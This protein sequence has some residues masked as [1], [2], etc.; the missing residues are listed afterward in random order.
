MQSTFNQYI[1]KYL[2]GQITRSSNSETSTG[3]SE[4]ASAITIG[5][6]VV[7]GTSKFGVDIPTAAFT[8]ADIYGVVGYEVNT[9]KAI[10]TNLISYTDGDQF[11]VVRKGY[12]AL[13]LTGTV[14]KGGHLYFVHT[15]GGASAIHTWRGD[16]DTD[17]ASKT[18]IVAL[19]AGVSGDIIECRINLDLGI[20]VS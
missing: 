4:S 5:N 1:K 8:Y 20:G 3:I 10:G 7:S 2:V 17:K 19:E 18:P 14:A 15:D 11:M 6:L 9:E 16:L 13:E 12:I